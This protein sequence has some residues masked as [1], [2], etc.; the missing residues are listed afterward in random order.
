MIYDYQCMHAIISSKNDM[1][2]ECIRALCVLVGEM[3]TCE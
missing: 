2:D 1:T 3:L